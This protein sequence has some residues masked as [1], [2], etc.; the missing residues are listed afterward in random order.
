MV[1][2]LKSLASVVRKKSRCSHFAAA[3]HAVRAAD[4]VAPRGAQAFGFLADFGA[5]SVKVADRP[6]VAEPT[7]EGRKATAHTA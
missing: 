1:D 3:L 7:G 2:G 6:A 4:G 5:G